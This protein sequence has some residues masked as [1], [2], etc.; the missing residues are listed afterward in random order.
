VVRGELSGRV[1]VRAMT[2]VTNRAPGVRDHHQPKESRMRKP[3]GRKQSP[4]T[5][6]KIGDRADARGKRGT[7]RAIRT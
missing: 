3:S 2:T 5:T 7:V 4:V 1:P 6:F